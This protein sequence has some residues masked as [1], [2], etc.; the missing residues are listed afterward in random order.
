MVYIVLVNLAGLVVGRAASRARAGLASV[1][2][3]AFA[4]ETVLEGGMDALPAN[5]AL[6]QGAGAGRLGWPMS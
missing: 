4:V 2:R 1:V 6:L 5:G 3:L